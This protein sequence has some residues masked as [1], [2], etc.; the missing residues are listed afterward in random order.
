MLQ[1]HLE[2]ASKAKLIDKLIV[3]TTNESGIEAI[4]EI[5][6]KCNCDFYNGSL[7]N[8]LERYYFAALPYQ[9]DY[10]VRITSDCPLIDPQL[11]DEVVSFGIENKVDYCANIFERFYPDGM[12]VEMFSFN[13]LKFAFQNAS[14]LEEKE[15]VTP[16]IRNN[17]TILG[18]KLFS[19]ISVK[20]KDN[21]GEVRL[22]LDYESDFNIICKLLNKLGEN[23]NWKEYADGLET[24]SL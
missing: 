19:S 11:I 8:V 15:H 12:D 21:F 16:F 14:T 5:A 24:L 22:T 4:N 9:P 13:A 23:A 18:G 7:N 20:N 17:S 10:V 1:I 2:R 6:K 3:A